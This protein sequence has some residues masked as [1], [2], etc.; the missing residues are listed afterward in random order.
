MDEAQGMMTECSGVGA[1]EGW[2]WGVGSGQ[3]DRDGGK[4]SVGDQCLAG[5]RGL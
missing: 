3:T 5:S 4:V 1:S 2:E